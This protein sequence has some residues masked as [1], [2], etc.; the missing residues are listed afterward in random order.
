MGFMP[1]ILSPHYSLVTKELLNGWHLH[2]R[3]V[4]PWTV[5]DKPTIDILIKMGVDGIIT[6]YPNLFSE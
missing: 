3:K 5:N 1:S 6:D 4:I 2:K